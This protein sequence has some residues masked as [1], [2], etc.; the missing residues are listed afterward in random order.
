MMDATTFLNY[1]IAGLILYVFYRLIV[2]ELSHLRETIERMNET[3]EKMNQTLEKHNMLL[4]Q[5][6]KKL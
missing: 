4:D 3:V 5:I 6:L 2:N 1:G